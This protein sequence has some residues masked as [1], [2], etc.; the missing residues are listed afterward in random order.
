MKRRNLFDEDNPDFGLNK[1][2][3]KIY[4]NFPETMGCPKPTVIFSLIPKFP[5]EDKINLSIAELK[6]WLIINSDGYRPIASQKLYTVDDNLDVKLDGIVL[7]NFR[8]QKGITSYFEILNN[9]Y[10]EAGFSGV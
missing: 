1:N 8:Y 10:I 2:S 3:R 7:N 9:G 5:N 6:N 4:S